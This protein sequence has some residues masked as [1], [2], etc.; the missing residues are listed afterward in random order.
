[1][2]LLQKLGESRHLI[3]VELLIA[4]VLGSICSGVATA[5]DAAAV[6]V[7]G[8]LILSA[9]QGALNRESFKASLMGGSRLYCKIALI[10]AGAIFLTLSMGRWQGWLVFPRLFRRCA[11]RPR[12]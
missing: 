8:A 12:L 6:G 3:P 2:T 7:L 1:M 4:A 10:Q 11:A 9:L 5:T